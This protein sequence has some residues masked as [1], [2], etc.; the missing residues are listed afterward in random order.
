LV[1]SSPI[2]L[3]WFLPLVLG[4]YYLVKPIY[5]NWVLLFF[6]LLFYGWGEGMM[7]TIML[8]SSLINYV[9]GIKIN[10]AKTNKIAKW[11]L[12]FGVTLNLLLLLYYKYSNFFI[13]NYNFAATHLGINPVVWDKVILPLGISFYTFHGISYIIDVYRKHVQ[14]QQNPF[15]LTLYITF[16]PQLIAGPII[17]YKDVASQ[18]DHRTI[19][20][21][22]F[23][24]GIKRFIIGLSK[25]IIIANIVGRIPEYTFNMPISELNGYWS[26]LGMIAI[27]IQLY[28]DFSGYSDMAIG[29]GRMFGFQFLENFNYPYISQSMKEIWSRWHISLSNWFRDYVYIPMG[30]NKKGILRMHLNLWTIFL[31]NGVWHGANWSFLI[32]GAYHGFLLTF[33]RIGFS[34]VL[35]RL[36]RVARSVYVFFVFAFGNILFSIEDIHHAY[37]YYSSLFNFST[38]DPYNR[39]HLYLTVEWY[40]TLLMG[41]ILAMPTAEF[42][43]AKIKNKQLKNKLEMVLLIGLFILSISELTNTTYNPFIY[44]R[45]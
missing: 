23:V 13:D 35:N 30:G 15:K 24:S 34:K 39:I 10:A 45:F 1:F 20:L 40:F 41:I 6:S 17:R 42:L 7:L 12:F 8:T 38:P 28:F 27:S 9:F 43:F 25:K 32:F 37:A 3:F 11:L 29:L 36:P 19:D 14:A 21:P 44:F 5:R 4:F 2:F 16:F 33:E 31:L 26:W 22:L 18:L